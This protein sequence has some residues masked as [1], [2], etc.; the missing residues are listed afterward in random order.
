MANTMEEMRKAVYTKEALLD[1]M[2]SYL[3]QISRDNGENPTVVLSD[4]KAS[5]Q[6]VLSVNEYNGKYKDELNK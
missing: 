6:Y 2:G 5:I 1:I 4:I 3:R